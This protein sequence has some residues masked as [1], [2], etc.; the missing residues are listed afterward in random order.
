MKCLYNAKTVCSIAGALLLF[1]NTL[2][3]AQEKSL[4][5]TQIDNS[6]L[7]STQT[8][9]LY[10][11]IHGE[12][13][14]PDTQNIIVEESDN[15]KDFKKVRLVE[16]TKNANQ[17]EGIS[18]FLLLDNSGSMWDDLEGKAT[19]DPAMTRMNHAKRAIAA[20]SQSLGVRDRLA[21]A[22]FNTQYT[23]VQ[24]MTSDAASIPLALEGVTRPAREEGYTELYGSIPTAITSFT[25]VVG[26]KALVI[27]S[28]GEHLSHPDSRL[29]FTIKQG[30]DAAIREGVTCYVVNFGT[31]RDNTLPDL[32]DASG[33]VVFNA[34]SSQDLSDI[35]E[36]IRSSILDEWAI[37]Y[38]ASMTAGDRRYVRVSSP[39]NKIPSGPARVYY[40]G[41]VL[42]T[43]MAR[44]S[45]FHLFAIVLPLAA[46]LALV[47]CKLERETTD[48]EIRLLYG[49]SS[50]QTRAFTLTSAQTV[51]GGAASSDI[52]IAGN[53][54][55]KDNAATVVYDKTRARYTI[56]AESGVTVNNKPVKNRVLEDGDVI[57]MAGTVVVFDDRKK[58]VK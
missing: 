36:R 19:A 5:I 1:C 49:A 24:P 46:W 43:G 3:F 16:V 42:G 15:G 51:I 55:L 10:L 58:P 23:I 17:S 44:P 7:V 54:S 6:R 50:G 25:E 57:N 26:R 32:A 27:L 13:F 30:I 39:S 9:R 38:I 47:F 28:D 18:F 22:T 48:A 2:F 33:G 21:L 56:V 11:S 20:F 37:R 45:W 29:D 53:P 12:S 41:G 34:A 8:I 4:S 52:T 35:Y 31:S 14:S 40:S